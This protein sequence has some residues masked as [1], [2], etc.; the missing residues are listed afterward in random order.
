MQ[1]LVERYGPSPRNVME[2]ADTES[3]YAKLDALE[4]EL[5]SA[6]ESVQFKNGLNSFTS[7]AGSGQESTT[8][9]TH[10]VLWLRR[11]ETEG[12]DE[13]VDIKCIRNHRDTL[14]VPTDYISTKI[15]KRLSHQRDVQRLW[16]RDLVSTCRMTRSA[17][18]FIYESTF[19]V[20][21]QRGLTLRLRPLHECKKRGLSA[22]DSDECPG[23]HLEGKAIELNIPQA[24]S[25]AS[26]NRADGFQTMLDAHT[27]GWT[28]YDPGT[29][30]DQSFNYLLLHTMGDSNQAFYIQ[31]TISSQHGA[32]PILGAHRLSEQDSRTW[33]EYYVFVS[34]EKNICCP[35]AD[36]GENIS[37]R[38]ARW[39]LE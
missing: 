9:V 38:F 30:K 22:C 20:M 16:F 23:C 21:V 13:Y 26:F 11:K 35:N 1:E 7:T 3:L 37:L 19:K 10:R 28:F 2:I 4:E 27:R 14:Y 29:P 32:E 8:H 39:G 6:I 17:G 24:R 33:E 25:T 18:G 34:L 5:V 15:G 12:H 36:I 31:N